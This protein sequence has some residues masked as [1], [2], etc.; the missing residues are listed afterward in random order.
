[1]ECAD[2]GKRVEPADT[3]LRKGTALRPPDLPDFSYSICFMMSLQENREMRDVVSTFLVDD[4][5][6]I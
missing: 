2:Q 3:G 1:M 4:S 6:P 5:L